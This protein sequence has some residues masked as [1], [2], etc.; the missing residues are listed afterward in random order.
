MGWMPTF[1]LG[2]GFNVDTGCGYSLIAET[3]RI[4]FDMARIPG[5]KSIE[6]LF[7]DT[8]ERNDTDPL[9]KLADC[10]M[11]ADY[12]LAQR[13]ASSDNLNCYRKFFNTFARNSF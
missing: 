12:Q 3:A 6:D 11:H 10:L 9:V 4:C 5:G 13:I 1:I 2:A 8:L 7:S